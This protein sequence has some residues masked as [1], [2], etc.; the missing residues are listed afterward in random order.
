MITSATSQTS[1][2]K[3]ILWK[4]DTILAITKPQLVKINKAL[5]NYTHL[6]EINKELQMG[7]CISDSLIS[8][9]K[10]SSDSKDRIIEAHSVINTKTNELNKKLLEQI[11]H[12]KKKSRKVGIGVGV[13]GT[14]FGFILGVLLAK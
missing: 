10:L 8:Y 6:K 12:D 1:Y 3:K 9:W 13:G 2:P 7:L 5:N 14:L 11:K 4:N